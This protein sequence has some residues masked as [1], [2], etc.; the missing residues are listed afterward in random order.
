M[1]NLSVIFNKHLTLLI[2]ILTGLFLPQKSYSQSS[3]NELGI[4]QA[5]EFAYQNSPELNRLK[6]IINQYTAQQKLVSGISDPEISFTREGI[7]NNAFLEQRWS[8]NQTIDFPTSLF[9]QKKAN[10]FKIAVAEADYEEAKLQLKADVKS[11]YTN[12]AYTIEVLTLRRQQVALSTDI[13]NIAT[14]RKEI[15]EASRL[16]ELQAHLQLSEARNKQE[17]AV[18]HFHSARYMLFNVLGLE[19]GDQNYGIQFPD[20]LEYFELFID[21]QDVL[22]SIQV[23]PSVAHYRHQASVAEANIKVSRSAYLPNLRGSYFSQ[24]FGNGFSFKGFEVGLTVP[25]WFSIKQQPHLNMVK[26]DLKQVQLSKENELLSLKLEAEN[27]WHSFEQVRLQID[28]YNES[29]RNESLELLELTREAYRVGEVPLITWL[30]AQ[31]TYLSSKEQYLTALRDYHLNAIN[32]E[33]FLQ[34]DLVYVQN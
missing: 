22:E 21:H 14:T 10:S 26:S 25:L 11:S 32:I 12:L 1:N 20:T 24:D 2:F 28:T 23:Y 15:G 13:K 19:E 33:K 30:E 17:E 27:S 16:D 3:F 31:R 9:A 34:L 4:Q 5:I 6:E 7:D 29:I 18:R 8:V